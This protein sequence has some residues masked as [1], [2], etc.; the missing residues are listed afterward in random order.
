MKKKRFKI[1][2]SGETMNEQLPWDKTARENFEAILAKIPI[3]SQWFP[4]IPKT[5]EGLGLTSQIQA[6]TCHLM[7]PWVAI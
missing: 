3:F 4:F 1:K 5:D 6:A 7:K 2:V